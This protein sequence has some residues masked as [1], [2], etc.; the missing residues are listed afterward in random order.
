MLLHLGELA[1]QRRQG[2]HDRELDVIGVEIG[3]E[4]QVRIVADAPRQG[5][6]PGTRGQRQRVGR[7][8]RG[9]L[10]PQLAERAIQSLRQLCRLESTLRQGLRRGEALE[11]CVVGGARAAGAVGAD[12]ENGRVDVAHGGQIAAAGELLAGKGDGDLLLRHQ[13]VDRHRNRDQ[14]CAAQDQQLG[15][16]AEA[17]E[18][19]RA[20]PG[21]LQRPSSRP[22]T[23]QSRRGR[24]AAPDAQRLSDQEKGV[25]VYVSFCEVAGWGAGVG[26]ASRS[27]GSPGPGRCTCW[28]RWWRRRRGSGRV[29]V[30][31]RRSS[32]P[33][34]TRMS[35]DAGLPGTA[36]PLPAQML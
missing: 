16:G 35:L 28:I 21:S 5:L 36:P 17:L 8:A 32:H 33:F 10:R 29:R 24:S 30:D 34:A 2:A 9:R 11:R 1:E 25:R 12:G 13:R 18:H 4:R 23:G 6:R 7:C 31:R 3:I 20:T 26:W 19:G 22:C 27:G 14:E 15:A